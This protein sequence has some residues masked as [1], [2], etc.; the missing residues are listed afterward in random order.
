MIKPAM[1][2]LTVTFG[3]ALAV[4]GLS[5]LA[6]QPV[7]AGQKAL[8]IGVGDYPHSPDSNLKAPAHDARRIGQLLISEMGFRKE[9]IKY[10]VDGEATKK[11]IMDGLTKWLPSRTKKGDRVIIF[12]EGHGTQ[13][14]DRNGDE[15]DGKDEALT[16]ADLKKGGKRKLA[17]FILDDEIGVALKSLKGRQVILLI[18]SCHSGTI[19]RSAEIGGDGDDDT[20]RFFLPFDPEL[21][22]LDTALHARD[23]EP[24]SADFNVHL[25]LSA[26]LPHQYAWGKGDRG[27]FPH[28]LIEAIKTKKAD[29]NK[30]GRITAG[31]IINYIRPKTEKWCKTVDKCRPVKF[32]PNM[33]PKGEAIVVWPY[34]AGTD[35]KVKG[36]NKD[37]VSDI[38]PVLQQDA[39]SI[40]IRPGADHKVGDEVSFEIKT[41]IDGYLTLFDLNA[42]NEMVLLFP[43]AEDLQRGKT[44]QI[45]AKSKLIIPDASYG[46]AFEAGLPTGKGQLMAIVTQDKID[47]SKLLKDH[48]DFEPIKKKGELVKKIS[49][50]LYAVW[51]KEPD[52]NRAVRWAVGYKDYSISQ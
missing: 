41:K 42:A 1:A 5:A 43:T 10:L 24:F 28:Y 23:N 38:L 45:R 31:E 33:D 20:Q 46:F 48:R 50:K 22:A 29:L 6:I 51:T 2:K 8:V 25:S 44:G 27:I 52:H 34:K 19:A 40:A 39:L 49:K 37:D 11:A 7:E 3:L 36:N 14:K 35:N 17:Q 26:A 15:A 4:I 32:T 21:G 12:Y 30:N 9:D 13:I 18:G 16:T 47:F